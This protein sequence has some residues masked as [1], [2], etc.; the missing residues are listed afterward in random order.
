MRKLSDWATRLALI[1]AATGGVVAACYDEVPVP[2]A[3][4]PPTREVKPMA[5]KPKPL[6]TPMPARKKPSVVET[7]QEFQPAT[8]AHDLRDAGTED[9]LHLPP[10]PDA[11]G[12]DAPLDKK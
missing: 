3:P 4:L 1:A 5:P 12:L 7:R 2:S 9:A 8:P 11:S 10:V 6:P